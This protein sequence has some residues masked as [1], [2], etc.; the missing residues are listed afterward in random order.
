M[1]RS[2]LYLRRKYS[3]QTSPW[4]LL[5]TTVASSSPLHDHAYGGDPRSPS[6][7]RVGYQS[8]PFVENLASPFTPRSPKAVNPHAASAFNFYDTFAI[9]PAPQLSEARPRSSAGPCD[10]N[11]DVNQRSAFD[12]TTIFVGGLEVHGRCTWDEQRLKKVF[13]QYGEIIDVKLVRP[14]G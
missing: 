4:R 3:H 13:G 7:G 8:T 12:S 11:A 14:G 1:V 10:E 9:P 2:Q 6:P 5:N